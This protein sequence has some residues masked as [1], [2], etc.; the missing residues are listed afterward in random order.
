MVFFCLDDLAH[1]LVLE[2]LSILTYFRPKASLISLV[3]VIKKL[4]LIGKIGFIFEIL[5]RSE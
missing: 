5:H 2:I 3:P 4:T 1:I